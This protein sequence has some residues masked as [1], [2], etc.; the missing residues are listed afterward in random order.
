MEKLDL[1]HVAAVVIGVL[2]T[3]VSTAFVPG[4]K[5]AVCSGGAPTAAQGETQK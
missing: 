5:D 1:K 3:V 4:F 2:L